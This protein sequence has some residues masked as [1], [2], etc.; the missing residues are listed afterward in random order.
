MAT[1]ADVNQCLAFSDNKGNSKLMFSE[2]LDTV[3]TCCMPAC[4]YDISRAVA[5]RVPSAFSAR[6]VSRV[7]T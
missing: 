2:E 1:A 4:R 6:Q 3:A 7:K 5:R